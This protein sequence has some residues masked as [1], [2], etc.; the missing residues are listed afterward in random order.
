MVRT[1]DP[2]G[3]WFPPP[4]PEGRGVCFGSGHRAGPG[5]GHPQAIEG[6]VGGDRARSPRA[7]ND[8]VRYRF[9]TD[10]QLVEAWA[11]MANRSLLKPGQLGNV[12]S[13]Y[14]DTP[15]NFDAWDVDYYYKDQLLETARGT[16]VTNLGRGPVGQAVRF[17]LAVGNSTVVQ[18]IRLGTEGMLLT[19]DTEV[20]WHESR[21]L[22]R[23]AFP[24]DS[25]ATE[26]VCEVAYGHV[27]RPTHQNTEWDFAKFEVCAH[28][29]VD[30]GD[31]RFG[32]A[33]LNDSKY[34]YSV[35]ENVLG[36]SLLRS[37]LYPDPD[38]DQGHHRFTY[39]LLPHVG[40]W[41]E[42][43]VVEA[44]ACLNRSPVSFADRSG[45][46]VLPLG[47]EGEGFSLEA[48]K[49]A[50]KEEAWILRVVENRGLGAEGV[51][52]GASNDAQIAETD[53]MEWNDGEFQPLGQGFR[54]RLLP[55]EIKTFKIRHGHR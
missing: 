18:T 7:R 22:L 32:V 49:K 10:G 53:L 23:T 54:F 47:V 26:A 4:D 12:L 21:R 25:L 8:E 50:E 40:T 3:G 39:A 38:A 51:V 17:D 5:L 29:W 36:L 16:L 42:A 14:E 31:A 9:N 11:K 43:G 45:E 46:L 28:R 33:L 52:R 44:A 13:Y 48:L 20:E 34:G 55:F 30:I 24:L 19:F 15:H 41:A 37:P 35:T 27:K 1:L 6:W 2:L